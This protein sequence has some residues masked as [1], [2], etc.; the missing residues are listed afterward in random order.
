M[1]GPCLNSQIDLCQ[2]PCS[3]NISQKEYSEL[4]SKYNELVEFKN[5]IETEKKQNLI[6]SFYMLSEDDKKDVKEHIK[7]YSL[8]EIESKLC[9]ICVRNK[10][11]FEKENLDENN[12]KVE[13]ENSSVTTFNLDE[14]STVPAWISACINTQNSK[15]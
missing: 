9:V 8:E 4:E 7:D 1:D 11:N 6:D 13:E 2:A 15:K 12:N 10:V 3:G 14:Q 5:T